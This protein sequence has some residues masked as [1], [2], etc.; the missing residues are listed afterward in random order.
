MRL[1]NAFGRRLRSAV[2]RFDEAHDV[3]VSQSEIAEMAARIA[4]EIPKRSSSVSAWFRGKSL[5]AMTT[6]VG[7]AKALEVDPGWLAFG[8]L[9]QA[10]GPDQEVATAEGKGPTVTV[11]GSG[12]RHGDTS[13]QVRQSESTDEEEGGSAK[14]EGSG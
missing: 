5:P 12:S 9:S 1:C 7:L 2:R 4:D 13:K 6:L 14:Q 3:D 10:P 11:I 8:E